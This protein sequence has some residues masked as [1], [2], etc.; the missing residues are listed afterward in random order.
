MTDTTYSNPA[1]ILRDMREK[2]GEEK[3]NIFIFWLDWGQDL[4]IKE[5]EPMRCI[6]LDYLFNLSALIDKATEFLR[7][8]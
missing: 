6:S 4:D 3:F 7:R 1:D 2:L 8:E 5:N